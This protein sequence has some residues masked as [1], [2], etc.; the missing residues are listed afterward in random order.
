LI[1]GV[2]LAGEAGWI[3]R[4]ATHVAAQSEVVSRSRRAQD[5]DLGILPVFY[6]GSD[7]RN[8]A[9]K[10]LCFFGTKMV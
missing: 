9:G 4:F 7:V 6:H 2:Q 10:M 1:R 8:P 3:L 5:I